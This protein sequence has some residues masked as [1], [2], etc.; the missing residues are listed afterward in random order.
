MICNDSVL[1]Y[2]DLQNTGRKVIGEL[3]IEEGRKESIQSFRIE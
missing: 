2:Y 3:R 1:L